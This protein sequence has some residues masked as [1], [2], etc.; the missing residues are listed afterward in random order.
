MTAVWDGDTGIIT[1][2]ATKDGAAV[3][4]S[5]ATSRELIAKHRGTGTVTTLTITNPDYANGIARASVQ[6]LGAGDYDLILRVVDASVTATYP[7]ADVGAA[8]FTVR[9]NIDAI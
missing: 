1:F 7:S 3:N 2:T 4:L 8:R 9:A 5:G 6:S